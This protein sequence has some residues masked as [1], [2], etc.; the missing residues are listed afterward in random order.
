VGW[1]WL[2]T[3][4][5]KAVVGCRSRY[6]WRY[7][8]I[9]PLGRPP[10]YTPQDLE[11]P[12]AD[13]LPDFFHPLR[14][15]YADTDAQGHVYFA[16]Y[17]T[18][19]DEGL[20]AFMRHLDWGSDTTA[21]RGVDFVFADAQVQYRSRAWFED[22]LHI[23]IGVERLGRTSLTTRFVVHRP[24]DDTVLAEGR[25]VQ[26]CLDMSVREKTPLPDDLR[27]RVGA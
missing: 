12:L 20:S 18:F 24:S 9:V 5:A 2:P 17:L 4:C 6:R 26:V 10:E 8:Q 14:V 3:S 23:H 15:R 27:Q 19:A 13:A 7:H 22:V 1:I 21:A 25:L 16:N 11:D